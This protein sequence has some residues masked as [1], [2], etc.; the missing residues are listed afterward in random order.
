ME[1]VKSWFIK[2]DY[3]E[4][5]LLYQEYGTNDFL[6]NL[7]EQRSDYT[8]RK[9]LEELRKISDVKEEVSVVE[10]K[11]EP[12]KPNPNIFLIK[13]LKQQLQQ[14]YRS[15][16]NNRYQL[17]RAKKDRVRKEYAFQILHLQ[18]KKSEIFE[19]LDYY[20]EY[21]TL[22]EP[23]KEK[24]C[25]TDEIQRL[26]VQIW[27]TKKRLEQSADK[28]R[29]RAKTENLLAEKQARLLELRKE[30]GDS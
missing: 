15:I 13:K 1:K 11:V 27:K 19:Q 18:R 26:Y 21:G 24:V 6:K 2:R 12:I 9:L 10:D 14:I 16:D 17:A 20:E 22:P 28:L 23:A 4:G 8:E 7:F 25:K 30:R 3:R 5:V 29:N